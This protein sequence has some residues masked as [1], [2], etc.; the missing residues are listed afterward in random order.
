[1]NTDD[2]RPN[3]GAGIRG[4]KPLFADG[5]KATAGPITVSLKTKQ[6]ITKLRKRYEIKEE[7]NLSDSEI[8]RRA[9]TMGLKQLIKEL[10]EE[11]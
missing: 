10:K 6:M 9:L 11:N 4:R 3:S 5:E 8:H 7:R 1:M 2:E